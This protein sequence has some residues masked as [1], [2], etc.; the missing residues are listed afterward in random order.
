ME[1]NAKKT[2]KNGLSEKEKEF[3]QF[4]NVRLNSG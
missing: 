1:G 2:S 3:D 4:V